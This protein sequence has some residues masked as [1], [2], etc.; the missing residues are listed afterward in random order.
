[1]K[2]HQIYTK[3][4][5]RN[6]NYIFE[7]SNSDAIVIDPLDDV[8]I[9]EFVDKNSL[10]LKTI[11]NTHEHFDHIQGNQALIDQYGCDVWS[12]KNCIDKVPGLS[13]ILEEGEI[14]EL[15]TECKI[16]VLETPGHTFAHLSLLVISH[17]LQEA[18]IAGDALFNAGVGN[19]R[20]GGDPET[21]Y[22]TI[23][24]QF[25]VLDDSVVVYPGHEYLENNLK[26]TLSVEPDNIDAA[27]WLNDL[28]GKDPTSN[29]RPITIGDERKINT[30]MRLD[31][32]SLR[33]NLGMVDAS[34]KDVFIAL[35]ERRDTW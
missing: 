3:S 34:D 24:K 29:F 26:F 23:S 35:R 18:V 30:F 17:D 10:N 11:I 15:D 16:K 28:K 32:I 2:I 6:W 20:N 33:S 25:C 8:L 13:R 21:L 14:I 9:N 5:M 27:Q 22:Q 1:M 19:C 7:L 31:S 4:F 12:H